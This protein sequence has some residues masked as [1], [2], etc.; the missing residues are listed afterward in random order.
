MSVTVELV[1]ASVPAAPR[2]S[3]T[4]PTT[5]TRAMAIVTIWP[6]GTM[7]GLPGIRPWS[8]PPAISEP[9]NVTEPMTAPRTTKIVVSIGAATPLG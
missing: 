2:I 4:V 1:R 8:L 7:I 3:A 6:P 5:A 9:V